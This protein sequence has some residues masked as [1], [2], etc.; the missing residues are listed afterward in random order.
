M[1]KFGAALIVVVVVV[2]Q[3]TWWG[4]LEAVFAVA[5]FVFGMVATRL[6]GWPGWLALFAGMILLVCAFVLAKEV[7]HV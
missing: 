2:A 4:A 7:G 3:R 5:A 1:L 6:N